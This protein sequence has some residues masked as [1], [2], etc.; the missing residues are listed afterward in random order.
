MQNIHKIKQDMCDI[1]RR[2][3]NRQFAAA[4]DG[5]ITVRVSD[6]EVLCTPT[7]HCKGFLKPDDIALVD[8]TY[9]RLQAFVYRASLTRHC[10]VPSR[11]SPGAP[12]R[13]PPPARF[14]RS[15]RS[16][17]WTSMRG[18]CSSRRMSRNFHISIAAATPM[19]TSTSARVAP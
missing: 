15:S 13:G 2:I 16:C 11:G 12:S 9:R 17:Q 14:A 10:A 8:M 3:Y 19:T 1:G 18:S 4:N 6:N 7:L 5:N